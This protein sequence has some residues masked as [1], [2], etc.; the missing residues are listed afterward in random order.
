ME[1]EVWG[2]PAWTFLHSVTL[3]YPENPT[4][5]DKENYNNFFNLLGEILPC[6]KCKRHYKE[7][8][9]EMPIKL[10]SREEITEWL[11][12]IHNKVNESNGKSLYKYDDFINKYSYMYDRQR[13]Y[14]YMI[15]IVTIIFIFLL[16]KVF[17]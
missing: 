2:P 3:N 1:P 6:D 4:I 8:I 16:Y 11:F 5:K 17:N 14:L 13:K 10:E 9:K 12:N 7:N 15:I